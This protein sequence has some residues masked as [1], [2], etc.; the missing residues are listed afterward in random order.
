MRTPSIYS[1]IALCIHISTWRVEGAIENWFLPDL[2]RTA[3]KSRCYRKFDQTILLNTF[4]PSTFCIQCGL[5]NQVLRMNLIE[6]LNLIE[7]SCRFDFTL[8]EISVIMFKWMIC[9]ASSILKIAVQKSGARKREWE[10]TLWIFLFSDINDC[11]YI[12]YWP[13]IYKNKAQFHFSLST[14][15]ELLI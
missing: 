12:I 6:L 14:S 4:S 8:P 11:N 2:A 5:G 3:L 10:K 7:N 1:L 9:A 15:G 13:L